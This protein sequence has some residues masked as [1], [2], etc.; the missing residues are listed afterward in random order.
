MEVA[1]V[2]LF[3]TSD[4]CDLSERLECRNM[5]FCLRL[6]FVL[7]FG[8]MIMVMDYEVCLSYFLCALC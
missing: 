7:A 8:K 6:F 2:V 4:A 5:I 3:E 1:R